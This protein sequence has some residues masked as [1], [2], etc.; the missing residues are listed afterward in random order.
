MKHV[1]HITAWFPNRLVPHEA[2]FIQ[3][4]LQAL[5]AHV[6]NQAW[7]IDVRPGDRWRLLRSGPAAQRTL[8]VTTALRRWLI[9]EWMAT[10]LI[11]W[12]W[13]TR[14]RRIPVDLIDFHIAYPNCTRIRLLRWFMRRPM[15]ITEHFSAYRVGFNATSKGA[16]RIKRIFHA[17]VPVIVVSRALQ[18]DIERFAGPPSPTMY[19]VDNA[20][21]EAIFHPAST[22]AA[23]EGRFFTIA[24]WRSPKR[25][26][27]LLDALASMRAAGFPARLRMAGDGPGMQAIRDRIAKLGL[28]A[29]VDLL[30]QLDERAVAD[31]MRHAHALL[32]ASD[33]ETYSAVCAEALCCG[34]PVIASN[35]GG[36]PEFLHA[37]LGVLVPTNTVEDWIHSWTTAWKPLLG[38]DRNRLAREMSA[39]AGAGPVGERYV[40]VLR[41]IHAQYHTPS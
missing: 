15:V 17:K 6:Q 38:V 5:D 30:G 8:L 41:T 10:L 26:D 37:G 23:V 22:A 1:L 27:L 28:T 31:E 13:F 18:G 7:H 39:R 21:S 14:D 12:A 9:I 35:V 29:H 3:R 36:I 40:D 2:P 11:L 25:P 24:G 16:R 32:H 33:Y 19:V 4:H 20:V 34:T